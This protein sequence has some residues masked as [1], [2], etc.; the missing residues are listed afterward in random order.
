MVKAPEA[1]KKPEK[2]KEPEPEDDFAGPAIPAGFIPTGGLE[3][4][5]QL[6]VQ[7]SSEYFQRNFYGQNV[8]RICPTPL[9]SFQATDKSDKRIGQFGF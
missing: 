1:A 3:I 8:V 7:K 4:F 5:G 6:G 9:Y 2:S